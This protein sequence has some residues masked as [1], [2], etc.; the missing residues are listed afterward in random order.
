MV[1]AEQIQIEAPPFFIREESIPDTNPLVAAASSAPADINSCTAPMGNAALGKAFLMGPSPRSKAVFFATVL[2]PCK[3]IIS[4]C[5]CAI[6]WAFEVIM[7]T[8]NTAIILNN[9]VFLQSFIV[10]I[11]RAG[12]SIV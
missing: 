12:K 3:G 1:R 7:F 11:I 8:C 5:N 2:K 6:I 9:L 10:I 4:F